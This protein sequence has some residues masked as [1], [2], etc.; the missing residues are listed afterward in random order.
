MITSRFQS[1][2]ANLT[3]SQMLEVAVVSG[4]T[5][6]EPGSPVE[7]LLDLE[8]GCEENSSFPG[9]RCRATVLQQ[10]VG[11]YSARA[12]IGCKVEAAVQTMKIL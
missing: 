2:G 4:K 9:E 11:N 7:I 8:Q 10:T 1:V 6:Q 12:L 3:R 5:L